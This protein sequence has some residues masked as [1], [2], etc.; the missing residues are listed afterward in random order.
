ML[1]LE[2]FCVS[3]SALRSRYHL[4]PS[5]LMACFS[6]A[7]LKVHFESLF[8]IQIPRIAFTVLRTKENSCIKSRLDCNEEGRAPRGVAKFCHNELRAQFRAELFLM[9]CEPVKS[10]KVSHGDL[11]NYRAVIP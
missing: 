8:E 10:A 2:G 11:E 9:S 4:V 5:N 7:H 6:N 3:S 1:V